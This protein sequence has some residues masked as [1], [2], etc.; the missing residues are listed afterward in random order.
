MTPSGDETGDGPLA[1]KIPGGAKNPSSSTAK[2]M[3]ST[4]TRATL[5]QDHRKDIILRR[6]RLDSRQ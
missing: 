6:K 2:E 4:A 5:R 3:V 1:T